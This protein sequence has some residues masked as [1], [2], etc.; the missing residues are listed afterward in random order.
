ME[1]GNITGLMLHGG[2]GRQL[3]PL[4]LVFALVPF[5]MFQQKTTNS[6]Q[7]CPLPKKNCLAPSSM[8]YQAC[9][10]WVPGYPDTRIPG[11]PDIRH[12]RITNFTSFL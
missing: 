2:N 7:M 9:F 8:K 10:G 4:P 12:S 1:P 5:E 3:P 6:S 11:Y